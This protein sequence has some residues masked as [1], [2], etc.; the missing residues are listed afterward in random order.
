M[1]DTGN[2]SSADANTD[3][4]T[5]VSGVSVDTGKTVSTDVSTDANTDANT[6][7]GKTPIRWSQGDI[8]TITAIVKDVVSKLTAEAVADIRKGQVPVIERL[9]AL[10]NTVLG[11]KNS[12][13]ATN[14]AVEELKKTSKSRS[15][16]FVGK[17]DTP[18]DLFGSK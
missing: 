17:E 10:S 7:A 8:D 1:S 6:F 18:K 14:Q 12:I 13:M 3:A 16:V 5:D 2:T 9:D 15:V 4:N 11:L